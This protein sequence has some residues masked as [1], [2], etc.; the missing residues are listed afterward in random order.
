MDKPTEFFYDN[1]GFSFDPEKE[2]QEQGRMRVAIGLAKAERDA[3]ENGVH[4][5]WSHD[6]M[7]SSEWID[8]DDPWPTWQCVAYDGNGEI[9]DSICGVDFGR[10]G[11]PH[12]DVYR[13]VVEAEIAATL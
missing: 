9:V 4:F 13:R 3:S 2:T 11:D 12:S 7:D 5:Q 10:D 1:A 6:G 8:T